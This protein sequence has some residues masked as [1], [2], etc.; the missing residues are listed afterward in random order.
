MRYPHLTRLRRFLFFLITPEDSSPSGSRSA[1]TSP[2][3]MHNRLAG[4]VKIVFWITVVVLFW[5]ALPLLSRI[6]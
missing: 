6:L 3:M 5:I 4:A 1:S 2:R